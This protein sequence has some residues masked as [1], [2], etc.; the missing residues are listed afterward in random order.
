MGAGAAG[1]AVED[2]KG[3]SRLAA[4]ER[5]GRYACDAVKEIVASKLNNRKAYGTT[6]LKIRWQAGEIQHV[7]VNDE[8]E[9]K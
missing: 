6:T 3:E 5:R 4:S 9:Y 1:S 2:N 7:S 8:V